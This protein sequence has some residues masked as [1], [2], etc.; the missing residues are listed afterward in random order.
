MQRVVTG[1]NASWTHAIILPCARTCSRSKSVP[2]GL[3]TRQ[4]SRKPR[5]GSRTEQKTSVTTTLSNCASGNGNV[6]S[7]Q[8]SPGLDQHSL[9]RLDRLHPH[10]ARGIVKREVLPT[11]GTHLKHHSL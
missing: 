5:S 3:S 2:P 7:R 9:I 4:I 6:S 10:D 1:V 8:T 11:T